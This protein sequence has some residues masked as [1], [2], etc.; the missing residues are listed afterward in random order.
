MGSN[1]PVA[2]TGVEIIDSVQLAERLSVSETWVKNR[3]RKAYTR[4]PIPSFRLG[5]FVRYLW[6]SPELTGWI[7]RQVSSTFRGAGSASVRRKA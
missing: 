4:D 7:E 2:E 5:H 3:T 1:F 6:G